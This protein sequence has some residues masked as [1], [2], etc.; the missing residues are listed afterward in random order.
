ML[1]SS[2][3]VLKKNYLKLTLSNYFI[4]KLWFILIEITHVKFSPL[5]GEYITYES[6]MFSLKKKHEALE[7]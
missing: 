5:S 6:H 4:A 7:S 3:L 1:K 2:I